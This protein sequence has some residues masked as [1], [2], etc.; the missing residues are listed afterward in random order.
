MDS[1]LLFIAGV[2]IVIL[3]VAF[4]RRSNVPIGKAH[5]IDVSHADRLASAFAAS[6]P[7]P[8]V[9]PDGSERL[10][11]APSEIIA[12][13]NCMTVSEASRLAAYQ[14]MYELRARNSLA[15]VQLTIFD[16]L[17][18]EVLPPL[19]NSAVARKA[20]SLYGRLNE[21]LEAASDASP[22]FELG[23]QQ[24][25][26]NLLESSW[27]SSEVEVAAL[28]AARRMLNAALFWNWLTPDERVSLAEPWNHAFGGESSP[29]L[30]NSR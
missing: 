21:L 27:R 14:D 22:I 9:A 1:G 30:L 10:G 11:W 24:I 12:R 2:T 13:T 26:A 23:Y 17:P 16:A 4:S 18:T 25:G 7:P 20:L 15:A 5:R 8:V 28:E 19:D 29:A 3:C 6:L